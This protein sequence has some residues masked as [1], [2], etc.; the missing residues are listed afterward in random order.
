MNELEKKTKEELAGLL[1][2][3]PD[4]HEKIDV[5]NEL[6]NRHLNNEPNISL[7]QAKQAE[8]LSKATKYKH[9]EA[10]ALSTISLVYRNMGMDKEY[11]ENSQKAL[12]LFWEEKDERNMA[13]C[14]LNIA[15]ASLQDEDKEKAEKLY[16]EL[17]HSDDLKVPAHIKGA[18]R[19]NIALIHHLR[20]E[21]EKALSLYREALEDYGLAGRQQLTANALGNL[22]DVYVD[23]NQFDKAEQCARDALTIHQSIDSSRGVAKSS[24]HLAG[25]FLKQGKL[26]EAEQHCLD[27][28]K[29]V[30][31]NN[32]VPLACGVFDTLAEIYEKTNSWKKLALTLKQLA[33]YRE[34]LNKGEVTQ[35]V[36]QLEFQKAIALKEKETEIELLRNVEGCS[37]V[38]R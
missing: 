17:L 13:A 29:I 31:K 4:N 1:T 5:L 2:H 20:K 21:P 35:Q 8:H 18:C 34:K 16:Y 33:V 26:E 10:Q 38:L 32:L 7:E 11:F 15:N 3:L 14:L 12:E 9:G 36:Q 30:I 6:A 23:L 25:V 37:L 27:A 22:A 24:L 28:N 19:S